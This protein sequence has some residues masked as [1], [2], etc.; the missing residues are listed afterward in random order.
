MSTFEQLRAMF[1][2][3][4]TTVIIG[5][6]GLGVLSPW[7]DRWRE[8]PP[9]L[10]IDEI[11]AYCDE[12]LAASSDHAEQDL[13][14]AVLSSDLQNET[15]EAV[16]EFLVPLSALSKGNPD[17]ELRKWRLVLLEETLVN[18]PKDALYGL[19]TLTEFW[20]SFGF[21]SDSPHEVQG[22]GNTISPSE[23]YRQDNLDRLVAHHRAWIEKERT[24]IQKSINHRL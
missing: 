15:R 9:L 3:N 12:K 20:L 10:T 23:Y 8:F 21:P 11:E 16:K 13:I 24:A 6:N 7:P 17:I 5:W 4:W 22:K 2:V 14:V 19:I 18:M 1:D